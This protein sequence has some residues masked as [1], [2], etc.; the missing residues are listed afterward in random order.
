M[1]GRGWCAGGGARYGAG[2]VGVN[3]YR[4]RVKTH[5]TFIVP[6]GGIRPLIS[7]W[8]GGRHAAGGVVVLIRIGKG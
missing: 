4:E 7:R 5:S 2:G 6:S 1:V 8:G 3:P